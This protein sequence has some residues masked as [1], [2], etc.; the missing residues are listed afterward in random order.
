ML[1]QDRYSI[2][3]SCHSLALT[4]L[5]KFPTFQVGLTPSVKWDRTRASQEMRATAQST[6]MLTSPAAG[7]AVPALNIFR[8]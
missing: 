2:P 5:S 3:I 8:K 7:G 1:V 6:V 4:I